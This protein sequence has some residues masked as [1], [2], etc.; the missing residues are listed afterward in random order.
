MLGVRS[1]EVSGCAVQLCASLSLCA[2]PPAASPLALC[3]GQGCAAGVCL[4][5]KP[6]LCF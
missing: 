5:S 3:V 1:G 2:C 4:A 6:G